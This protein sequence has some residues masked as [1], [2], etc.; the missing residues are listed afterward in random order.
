MGN[1]VL[2]ELL[3]MQDATITL[4]PAKA[5]QFKQREFS[6]TMD[7]FCAETLRVLVAAKN[8]VLCSA[9]FEPTCFN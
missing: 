7:L 2:L 9:H 6:A 5:F 4:Q 3:E 1:I 8:V